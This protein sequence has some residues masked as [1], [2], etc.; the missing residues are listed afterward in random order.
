MFR[1]GNREQSSAQVETTHLQ[2]ALKNLEKKPLLWGMFF[3]PNHFRSPSP[4]FHIKIL[5]EA[6][7]NK[8]FAVASP[9]ESAKSTILSYLFPIHSICYKKKRFIVIVQNT[10]K[11]AAQTLETIKKEI[12][13]N[14][15]VKNAYNIE[16]TK[17]AEGDSILRH[18]DGFETRV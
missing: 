5:I 13:D 15:M 17:D 4:P 14:D 8:F 7:K 12:R 1:F 2:R 10:Y 18:P 6:I 11:K 16:I 3:T 9:R